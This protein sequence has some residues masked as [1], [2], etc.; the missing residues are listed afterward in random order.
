VLA[1]VKA[2]D[3]LGL[4]QTEGTGK[5]RQR[6]APRSAFDRIDVRLEL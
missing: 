5:E 2:L 6:K 3:T 4:I 1:D